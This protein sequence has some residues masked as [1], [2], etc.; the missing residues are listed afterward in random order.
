MTPPGLALRLVRPFAVGF[1]LTAGG[2]VALGLGTVVTDLATVGLAV[3]VALCLALALEP[4]VTWFERDGM[5]RRMAVAATF[6]GFAV[7]AAVLLLLAVPL[8]AAQ[9]AQ[10]TASLPDH[11]REL[12]DSAWL[13]GATDWTSGGATLALLLDHVA[14]W[15]A[16]PA[17]GLAIGGGVLA[18]GAGTLGS[19]G[20]V[21]VTLALT[22]SLLVWFPGLLAAGRRLAPAHAR[23]R[24]SAVA[25]DL[26]NSIGRYI[27]GMAGQAAI[28]AVV[29]LVTLSALRIPFALL[30][31]LVAFVLA[32]VPDVGSWV[33]WLVG[34]ALAVLLTGWT[35]V[36]FAGVH[37]AYVLVETNVVAGW[38]RDRAVPLPALPATLGALAGGALFGVFGAVVA[39]PATATI[40]LVLRE[41][42]LPRQDAR[43]QP[44]GTA[45]G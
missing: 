42:H 5:S 34:S 44:E 24:V 11:L 21:L 1:A 30:L 12:G 27:A 8:A 4:L 15:I 25:F 18:V 33:F 13:R 7:T 2:L 10:L 37:L 31:A 35:G 16:E 20:A 23:P 14:G 39:V 3:T 32:L 19:I 43:D 6:G 38:L 9:A 41:V 17:T 36:T 45:L 22:L 29:V 26:T 40:L 28:N